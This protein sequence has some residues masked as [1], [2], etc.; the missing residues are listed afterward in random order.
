MILGPEISTDTAIFW[1][2]FRPLANPMIL[3]GEPERVPDRAGVSG[4]G[5]DTSDSHDSACDHDV[6]DP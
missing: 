6:L 1:L 2:F 3:D 4:T 5:T